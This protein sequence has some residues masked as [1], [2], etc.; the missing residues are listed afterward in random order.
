VEKSVRSYFVVPKARITQITVRTKNVPKRAH[1]FLKECIN[2]T[3][4]S[5]QTRIIGRFVKFNAGYLPVP[6]NLPVCGGSRSSYACSLTFFPHRH[7]FSHLIYSDGLTAVY[8]A[9]LRTND[10][11]KSR[12]L[13][14]EISI[15]MHEN[16]H[17]YEN[18]F[19]SL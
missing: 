5:H 15:V 8:P 4:M 7:K 16:F 11:R 12:R 13:S 19:P 1:Y 10:R 2:K 6:D 3:Y 14:A 18:L 9:F 17:H